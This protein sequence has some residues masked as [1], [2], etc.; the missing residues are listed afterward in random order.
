ML[1]LDAAGDDLGCARVQIP[2]GGARPRLRAR[3]LAI[4]AASSHNSPIYIA[5]YGY[6]SHTYTL[7]STSKLPIGL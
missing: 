6:N 1:R 5:I 7:C 2:R 3:G 4:G